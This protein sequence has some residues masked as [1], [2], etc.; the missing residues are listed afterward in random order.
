MRNIEVS[1]SKTLTWWS[2]WLI[3]ATWVDCCCC[4]RWSSSFTFTIQW[5]CSVSNNKPL[6]ADRKRQK[7]LYH[8][9]RLL[10][11]L[12]ARRRF[13]N[14]VLQL[15]QIIT[16]QFPLVLRL[17]RLLQL[18]RDVEGSVQFHHL[19]LHFSHT[20]L[21][22]MYCLVRV[23]RCWWGGSGTESFFFFHLEQIMATK[24]KQ[25]KTIEHFGTLKT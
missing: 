7:S 24:K 6:A 18:A 23:F 11:W 2:S 19:S 22:P 10:G 17:L 5:T 8:L 15:P 9:K 25:T 16:H 20:R 12:L 4:I 1:N 14:A 13:S 3:L 21:H